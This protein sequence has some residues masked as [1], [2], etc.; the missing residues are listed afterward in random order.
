M[1]EFWE[2]LVLPLLE[3]HPALTLTLLEHLPPLPVLA[4]SRLR[5]ADGVRTA[6]PDRPLSTVRLHHEPLVVFHGSDRGLPAPTQLWRGRRKVFLSLRQF[7]CSH[8][9][10]L[11]H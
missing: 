3:C 9:F 10:N 2:P 11:L 6:H 8:A 5:A 7:Y 4:C 1:A